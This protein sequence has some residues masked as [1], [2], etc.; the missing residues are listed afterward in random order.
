M[1]TN[2]LK[3][4]GNRQIDFYRLRFG[5]YAGSVILSI[6]IIILLFTHGLNYGIDF[7]G[8]II[9]EVRAPSITT[10]STYR[11]ILNDA[12]YK[13]ATVQ[14]F[15]AE[16]DTIIRLQPTSGD[17]AQEVEELKKILVS[18]I[19]GLEFRKTDYVGPKAGQAM[20]NKG[21]MATF[22]A[23]IGM[24]LYIAVRFGLVFGIGALIALFHDALAT[25]GFYVITQF[26]F[27]LSSIAAI[28]TVIGYSVNDSVVVFDRIREN[29]NK[30]DI[31]ELGELI[32]KSINETLSRT[33]I[34]TFTTMLACIA[35][36]IWG[37]DAL[38][39]FSAAILFGITFGIYSTIFVASPLLGISG[40]K[41][42]TTK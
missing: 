18:N 35:L 40:M 33:I 22:A 24:M 7:S 3:T 41:K 15:G 26:E 27:D 6:L 32:N 12:G 8:G 30:Y 34:T 19:P 37:G 36:V 31:K 39:G 9:V 14:S 16:N 38:R 13:G 29:L 23:L 2:F 11:D 1:L 21:I 17:Y 42:L 4:K 25:L 10:D 20:I 5:A 28:L